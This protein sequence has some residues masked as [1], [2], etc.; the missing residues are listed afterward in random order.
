MGIGVT[1]TT[2][3]L[4]TVPLAIVLAITWCQQHVVWRY[5]L[6]HICL[7]LQSLMD[8]LVHAALGNSLLTLL[9]QVLLV[10]KQALSGV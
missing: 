1:L 3:S 2:F 6:T 9:A 8:Y 5:F 7:T 10:C 4:T